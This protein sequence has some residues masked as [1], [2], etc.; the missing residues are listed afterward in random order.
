MNKKISEPVLPKI[1]VWARMGYVWTNL[2]FLKTVFYPEQDKAVSRTWVF[3]F[4]WNTIA[5]VILTIGVW[6]TFAQSAV[7]WVE[8]EWWITVP[9]FEAQIEDGVFSTNLPQPYVIFEEAGEALVVIDTAELEYNEESLKGYQ[10]G[11]VITASEF[12]AREETGEYRKFSFSEVEEDFTFTKA[13]METF[14]YAAKPRLIGVAIGFIFVGLWFVLC[15][16][17]LLTA[18][19]WALVFWI[20]GLM[21]STPEWTYGKSYLSV[22]NFYV[23]PLVFESV[24]LLIGVGALPFSTFL[25][26]GLVFG[27]N[28]YNLKKEPLKA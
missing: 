6:F 9:D 18:A 28:F 10:G 21:A 11:V 5:A 14:W 15:I 22:L 19:W 24:L 27:V 16:W 26:L 13:D 7:S 17:R 25:V 2:S 20:I 4:T 23:I 12:I 1:N 8:N 3:W